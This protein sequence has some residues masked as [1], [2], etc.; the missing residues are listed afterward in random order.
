MNR[1][2]FD[3]LGRAPIWSATEQVAERIEQVI[4]GHAM[5]LP[6]SDSGH[7]ARGAITL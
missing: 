3:D 7:G 1:L 6:G 4:A 5:N 2:G